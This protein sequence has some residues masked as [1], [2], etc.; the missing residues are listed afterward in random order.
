MAKD[1]PGATRVPE[2]AGLPLGTKQSESEYRGGPVSPDRTPLR[3]AGEQAR[4]ART[5]TEQRDYWIREARA[6]GSTLRAIAEAVGLSHT[7]IQK[8]MERGEHG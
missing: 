4:K 7:A 5:A 1:A 2:L 8:I 6:G 3:I